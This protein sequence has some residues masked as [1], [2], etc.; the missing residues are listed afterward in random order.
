[1]RERRKKSGQSLFSQ[2]VQDAGESLRQLGP[3]EKRVVLE[4]LYANNKKDFSRPLEVGKKRAFPLQMV[5]RTVFADSQ[6]FNLFICASLQVLE[7]D[8]HL[9]RDKTTPYTF[10]ASC[11]EALVIKKDFQALAKEISGFNS[12]ETQGKA[13]PWIRDCVEMFGEKPLLDW[14]DLHTKTLDSFI[15][16]DSREE[17]GGYEDSSFDAYRYTGTLEEAQKK[18]DA[19]VGLDDIKEHVEECVGNQLYSMFLRK[20]YALKKDGTDAT[21]FPEGD[22]KNMVFFGSPGVGKTTVAKCL[23]E[24]FAAH[25][26]LEDDK[27]IFCSASE[28]IGAYVGHTE[29][30]LNGLFAEAEGGVIIIDE[31]DSW[32]Q[33]SQGGTSYQQS[34]ID[35]LNNLITENKNTVVILTGY[36]SRMEFLLEMNPGLAGRFPGRF[37]FPDYKED[38][39]REI[40]TRAASA[41][42]LTID[43]EAYD[44]ALDRLLEAKEAMGEAFGN[45]RTALSVLD[46]MMSAHALNIGKESLTFLIRSDDSEVLRDKDLATLHVEDVPFFDRETKTFKRVRTARHPAATSRFNTSLSYFC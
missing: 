39:L 14:I 43:P 45:A 15:E 30:R 40:L 6:I 26:L 4:H 10:V 29:D 31:A 2:T 44:V 21:E 16:E 12:K 13:A 7:D 27:I 36:P 22:F 1:M 17:N 23:G 33:S 38:E 42:G 20:S 46:A 8:R 28:L 25:G 34:A 19:L 41:R 37:Y 3:V 11:D 24:L 18:L 35:T 32:A 9:V 5:Y